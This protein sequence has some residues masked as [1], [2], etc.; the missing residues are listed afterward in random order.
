[1]ISLKLSRRSLGLAAGLFVLALVSCETTNKRPP[2]PE[3]HPAQSD[4]C[5]RAHEAND[6]PRRAFAAAYNAFPRGYWVNTGFQSL[7]RGARMG[8]GDLDTLRSTFVFPL[9]FFDPEAYLEALTDP[10][11]RIGRDVL[12]LLVAAYPLTARLAAQGIDAVLAEWTPTDLALI[13]IAQSV[14][15]LDGIPVKV[16]E[17]EAREHLLR[18]KDTYD[19]GFRA[20]SEDTVNTSPKGC[21]EDLTYPQSSGNTCGNFSFLSDRTVAE[22]LKEFGWAANPFKH[23]SW[24]AKLED[25]DGEA[26]YVSNGEADPSC[27]GQSLGLCLARLGLIDSL[28]EDD[29]E[30][31]EKWVE[32][33]DELDS[34]T[35]PNGGASSD[36]NWHK[37]ARGKGA[38]VST[39][40]NGPIETACQEAEAELTRGCDV[41]LQY[42]GGG[43]NHLEMVTG[44]TVDSA[45]PKKCTATTSSWGGIADTDVEYGKVTK[46]SDHSTTY[47]NPD[48][49]YEKEAKDGN[50]T[51]EFVILC[52]KPAA[53]DA[54]ADKWDGIGDAAWGGG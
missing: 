23:K 51:G 16:F 6:E 38:T 20:L 44:L 48:K 2:Q 28:P 34:G 8:G 18:L 29:K 37:Y 19:V 49:D 33:G 27:V 36:N 17:G 15:A 5:A 53:D 41:L 10:E 39:A 40:W 50:I 45:Y 7:A 26:K 3:A 43:F 4:D 14:E 13:V 24:V 22:S 1:M 25:V 54:D 52:K 9:Q 21:D 32:L 30:A 12:E 11:T 42:R 46:K 47:K 31:C 35:F